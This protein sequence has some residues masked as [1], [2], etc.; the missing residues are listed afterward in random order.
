MKQLT[1]DFKTN[2]WHSQQ[3]LVPEFPSGMPSANYQIDF[4]KSFD[5]E[6]C[7][8]RHLLSV[9]FC[10]DNRQAIGTNLLKAEL[11]S[12]RF[13]TSENRVALNALVVL[14]D[15]TKKAGQWD[16][17]VGISEEY[18]AALNT[19]YPQLENTPILFMTV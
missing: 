8:S 6:G 12:A 9:E 3:P 15:R 5:A 1:P 16:G 11:A 14:S 18:L 2:R 4:Q 19:C 17:S 7:D 13:E 10:F